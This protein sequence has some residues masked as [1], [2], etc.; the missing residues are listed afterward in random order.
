MNNAKIHQYKHQKLL[1]PTKT[2]ANTPKPQQTI[3]PLPA[4]NQE[5]PLIYNV[6]PLI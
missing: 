4:E 5:T 6:I 3:S 2:S 1:K